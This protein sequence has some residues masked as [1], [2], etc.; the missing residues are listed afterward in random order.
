[1]KKML[2]ICLSIYIILFATTLYAKDPA[3]PKT[4]VPVTSWKAGDIASE[5]VLG[6]EKT[7]E[8]F[9][10]G[11][12][13]ATIV[14]KDT[15]CEQ[16]GV[17]VEGR[18]V[19]LDPFIIS[20][21]EVTQ[22]LYK[23]IMINATFECN[24]EQCYY[25]SMPSTAHGLGDYGERLP[26][27]EHQKLRPVDYLSWYDMVCFCNLLSLRLGLEPAY[28]IIIKN[29][30]LDTLSGYE[31]NIS[32][33]DVE[34]IQGAN[35]YRLPTEAEWEFAARG[36]NPDSKEW[37]YAFSGAPNS[38]GTMETV[39]SDKNFDKIGWY[40]TNANKGRGT[41]GI[42]DEYGEESHSHE[43][44]VKAANSL[45]IYDM[46]GNVLEMCWD[47]REPI[48]PR[49]DGKVELNP[50]GP[51]NGTSKVLRG[52]SWGTWAYSVT[53][54]LEYKYNEST[55][56]IKDRDFT[57]RDIGFRLVRTVGKPD[58]KRNAPV[59]P[60]D[61]SSKISAWEP[62]S[63]AIDSL[64]G[65]KNT[66]IVHATT[67]YTVEIR[68]N[69]DHPE[70]PDYPFFRMLKVEPFDVS[71]HCVTRELYKTLM[72]GQFIT[73]GEAKYELNS[74]PRDEWQRNS[75]YEEHKYD[76]IGDITRYDAMYFC[77]VLSEKLGRQPV[78][79][80]SNYNM[81]GDS[82]H[83]RNASVKTNLNANGFRLMTS[84]EAELISRYGYSDK[85]WYLDKSI[86]EDSKI[87]PLG[88]D[89]IISEFFTETDINNKFIDY[90]YS[91]R[92]ICN[93]IAS[94]KTQETK[95]EHKTQITSKQ[96]AKKSE[97]Q[98]KKTKQNKKAGKKEDTPKTAIQPLP[99]NWKAG[100]VSTQSVLGLDRTKEVFVLG[101]DDV[102]IKG[103]PRKNEDDYI[104]K[105]HVFHYNRTVR[106]SPFIIG[107]YEVTNELY[108]TVMKNQ[109]L[110]F[111]GKEYSFNYNSDD[112]NYYY[113]KNVAEKQNL[114]PHIV[115]SVFDAFY[116]CN[117][118][119]ELCG[120]EKVYDINIHGLYIDKKTGKANIKAAEVVINNNANGYR[121]PTDAEWE[122]AA[123]GGNPQSSQWNYDY[124]GTGKI[125]DFDD[126]A[127]CN[128]NSYENNYIE[129]SSY[130]EK[131]C[132]IHETGLKKADSLG[133]YDIVGNVN[134]L[135]VCIFDDWYNRTPGYIKKFE[136]KD[137]VYVNP[138]IISLVT[139]ERYVLKRGSSYHDYKE[140]FNLL[141]S[142]EF[143]TAVPN[144]YLDTGIRL[145]RNAKPSTEQNVSVTKVSQVVQKE[146]SN[147]KQSKQSKKSKNVK[148]AFKQGDI[149]KENVLGLR[150]TSEV[151]A[152]GTEAVIVDGNFK[153]KSYGA[154]VETPEQINPFVI[155]QYEITR[156]LYKKVMS[157]QKIVLF[158][159][160][161]TLNA[162]PSPKYDNGG[163]EN[164]KP[165]ENINA[166]D[167]IYF[168]N[169]L[170]E[171]CGLEKAYKMIVKA[172]N[173]EGHITS[174]QVSLIEN[175]NGYR[176]P[177]AQEWEFALRGGKPGTEEWNDFWAGAGSE[178]ATEDYAWFSSDEI[179]LTG[180]YE[181]GRKKCNAL[182]LYDMR[183]NVSE[184]TFSYYHEISTKIQELRNDYNMYIFAGY[185][186][187]Y[188]SK[189][190]W[191]QDA[192]WYR[193]YDHI[194]F[195]IVRSVNP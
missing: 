192:K 138:Y 104:G 96:A 90:A 53:D 77:N 177:T 162:D 176:L 160:E 180:S 89:A 82:G 139:G 13:G 19:H 101:M 20:K 32:D 140:Y 173:E 143:G 131:H 114:M 48:I 18:T 49:A 63:I 30:E 195:R 141:Y 43:T 58:A 95:Q 109:K 88:M 187:A 134:E 28:K 106:L 62:G 44:G 31:Y 87:T 149:A 39:K 108:D 157:N 169:A 181:V 152:T 161:L 6:F 10:T 78:Y 128:E 84:K 132:Q 76:G 178:D 189:Y 123:R 83:I 174:A 47:W 144:N 80:F 86:T 7:A 68:G 130:D 127:W 41:W 24:G 66:E 36:G 147:V 148:A 11:P 100:D 46:S 107:C 111:N 175:T 73:I 69:I 81:F 166:Y 122:A 22:E 92:L 72:E 112:K 97:K 182:G 190:A 163:D 50:T 137:L 40:S 186:Q 159:I 71:R 129:D 15:G 136:E 3:I 118:L 42:M 121:I 29:A 94:N 151:Y 145:A 8:V 184:R 74:D 56:N 52:S 172:V 75:E 35:G 38:K 194:G 158:G 156:E 179:K 55:G 9:A 4:A 37:N 142:A 51:A 16:K 116:F 60:A 165:V 98:N 21:F 135:S 102:T 85:N 125:E 105:S 1:M 191:G 27:S 168:C 164:L 65:L 193:E 54:R 113:S 146:S 188:P 59:I 171:M 103:D 117:A 14:G 23:E 17:F 93:P 12:E 153:D 34:L 155:G 25:E 5:N 167:A 119:S 99:S 61:S 120:L 110:V 64:F 45:G 150:K 79:E 26:A 124:P 2:N 91:F 70:N 67:D 154:F 57:D 126:Y 33:A 115:Y 185:W 133:L 183:G 170:S